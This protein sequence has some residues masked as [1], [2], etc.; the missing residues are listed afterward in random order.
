MTATTSSAG[1]RARSR[2]RGA[3]APRTG[4]R[5]T[6]LGTITQIPAYLRLMGGLLTDP[7]VSALDKL[8]LGVAIAYVVAPI[9]LIPDFIPF[10]GQVDDVFI[11]VLALRR[12]I[13]NAGMRVIRDHW[14]GPIEDLHPTVLQ[15]VLLAAAFFL[16][17]R[18]RR[19]L[20]KIA[21]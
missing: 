3:R 14:D 2:G 19:R 21:R 1:A 12:L 16:P 9:D 5:R 11:V 15:E 6:L 17:R 4:A 10:L 20:R 8:L 7:R 18:I 13:S